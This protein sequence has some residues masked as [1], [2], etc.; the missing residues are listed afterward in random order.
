MQLRTTI[1]DNWQQHLFAS[2]IVFA[3]CCPAI[4]YAVP[5]NGFGVYGGL[6]G[7]TENGVTSNGLSIGVDAQFVI[8]DSW[9]LNSFLMT[10]AEN[11]SVS[12]TVS[13]ELAGMQV[14]RWFGE[15]FVGGQIFAHDRLIVGN[16]TTQN[17]A[18]GAAPGALAGIEYASGWG[19]EIQVDAFEN[20]MTPG[21]LRNAV[22][23][24]LTY[25]WY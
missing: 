6:I 22:R 4:A 3:T 20:S 19:G 25:R 10:S 21:V 5:Q 17:S 14:R 11:S 1:V 23:L 9:S 12:T 15:W 8:N 18:Y 7:A 2:C 24:H 16:G 13:D